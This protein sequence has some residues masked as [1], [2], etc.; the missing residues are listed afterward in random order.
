MVN[1]NPRIE[2][3]V[4]YREKMKAQAEA[5]REEL[6][7]LFEGGVTDFGE[8]ARR[9]GYAHARTARQVLVQYGKIASSR[10]PRRFSDADREKARRMLEDGQSYHAVAIELGRDQQTIKRNLPG[11]KTLTPQESAERAVLVKAMR[12]LERELR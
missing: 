4:P 1:P 6:F 11:Y 5:R 10:D 3:F 7:A 8:L 12:K 2:N 9:V